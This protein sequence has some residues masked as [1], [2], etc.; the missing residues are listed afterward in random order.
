[1][2]TINIITTL[3]FD[4]L[5]TEIGHLLLRTF[6]NFSAQSRAHILSKSIEVEQPGQPEPKFGL[7]GREKEKISIGHLKIM[8]FDS[9]WITNVS[10]R[11][12]RENTN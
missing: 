2:K 11:I 12:S 5:F 3:V 4:Y 9:N 8:M 7:N 1:M 6:L 10:L